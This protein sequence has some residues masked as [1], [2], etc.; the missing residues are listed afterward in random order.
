MD[1][2]C[3]VPDG[4]KGFILF[5]FL[6][7]QKISQYNS[8]I[9]HTKYI[10]LVYIYLKE[11]RMAESKLRELS[12]DLYNLCGTVR[13]ILVASINTAKENLQKEKINSKSKPNIS[14]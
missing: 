8:I 3:E 11:V 9:S 12:T 2:P 4:V 5:H 1:F 13:R 10:S 14:V 7:K 6:R